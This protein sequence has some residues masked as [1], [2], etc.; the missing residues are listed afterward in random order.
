MMDV[1]H[2][3]H[4]EV[5]V[6]LDG[7]FDAGAATRLSG[8][9]VEISSDDPLVLDF[10]RVRTC[11]DFGLA[12]VAHDLAVRERLVIRGLTRHHERMLRYF[13]VKL[14]GAPGADALED[15]EAS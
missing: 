6:R 1:T 11:E 8:W 4:G 5:V 9:L 7:N 3:A 2:G 12:A 14:D 10:S 15:R 13:G